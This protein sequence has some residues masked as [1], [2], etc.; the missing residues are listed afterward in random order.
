MKRTFTLLAA[1]VFIAMDL[2]ATK[3]IQGRNS[4]TAMRLAKFNLESTGKGIEHH[5][6]SER[7]PYQNQATRLK[8][9]QAIKQRLDGYSSMA[10]DEITGQWHEDE[11]AEFTYDANW[12][13]V[14]EQYYDWDEAT[15]QLIYD[16]NSVYSYNADGQVNENLYSSFDEV[17]NELIVDIKFQY[18]YDT[19]GNQIQYTFYRLDKTTNQWYI[20]SKYEYSYDL[21]GKM[22]EE[23]SSHWD[24]TTNQLILSEKY[25]YSYNTDGNE[26]LRSRFYWSPISNQWTESD[27]NETFYNS[28][29]KV[30]QTLR[31]NWDGTQW[32]NSSKEEFT[33][34]AKGNLTLDA[35]FSF[36]NNQWDPW[37]KYANSFDDKGNNTQYIQYENWE[38][39]TNEWNDVWKS[40]YIFNNNYAVTDLIWPFGEF[41]ENSINMII[42]INDYDWNSS[43]KQWDYNYQTTLNYSEVNVTSVSNLN[44]ELSKVY[45]NPCSESVSIS[46]SGPNSQINFELFDL[47][48]R[49]LLSK[50]ISNNEKVNMEGFRSGLYLYKLNLDGKM[51]SGK[52]V[53]E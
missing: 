30:K 28:N 46:I 37:Y 45:P 8:S 27:K 24:E 25:L 38:T 19:K 1:L 51:Q 31:S 18:D 21:S 10:L 47:Q 12:R 7:K 5:L 20:N 41:W 6:F 17:T 2:F 40:E 22:T 35:G 3:P 26:S 33:Y 48:G 15:N 43:T 23:I 53:K 16:G 50:A 13:L 11:K 42:E 49:K 32:Y 52:L 29:G 44:T 14:E 4:T 9:T 39:S 36:A 34:D